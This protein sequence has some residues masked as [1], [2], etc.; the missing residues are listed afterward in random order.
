[1]LYIIQHLDFRSTSQV[2]A[3][4]NEDTEVV[5]PTAAVLML[6]YT[7]IPYN[8]T[9]SESTT[10][11]DHGNVA[12]LLP[13]NTNIITLPELKSLGTAIVT[14]VFSVHFQNQRI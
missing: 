5:C 8:F 2:L 10:N 9:N 12:R 14:D 11:A 4:F 13:R 7:S 1:M 3:V 6:P